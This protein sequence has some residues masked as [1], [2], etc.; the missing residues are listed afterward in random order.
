MALEEL[1]HTVLTEFKTIASADTIIGKPIEAG[2]STIIPIS[3]VSI[4]FAGGGSSSKDKDKG[5]TGTGGGATI[6]PVAFIIVTD[7]EV[8]IQKIKTGDLDLGDLLE[9]VPGLIG[10]L[11]K[12]KQNP[13][14]K[15]TPEEKDK[16]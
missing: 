15:K 11:F 16:K 12:K 4:G 13:D 9:K 1:L 6:E 8:S 10:R 2:R 7:G 5:G 14:D 3:K